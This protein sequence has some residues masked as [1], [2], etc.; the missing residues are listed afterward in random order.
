MVFIPNPCI[1]KAHGPYAYHFEDGR[2]SSCID[3]EDPDHIGE[4]W[5][6]EMASVI[7]AAALDIENDNHEEQLTRLICDHLGLPALDRNTITVD[8]DLIASYFQTA[9]HSATHRGPRLA[10]R[11][12]PA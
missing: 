12:G 5:P 2:I 7:T 1:A 3:Y 4:H 8:R 6:N 10:G 9:S 11:L